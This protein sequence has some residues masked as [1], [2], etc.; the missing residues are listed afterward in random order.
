MAAFL[1]FRHDYGSP[2][3][4][5][6]R[7]WQGRHQKQSDRLTRKVCTDRTA[8]TSDNRVVVGRYVRFGGSA[9]EVRTL[10]DAPIEPVH[11][12]RVQP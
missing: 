8:W 7:R 5:V 4:V 2:G 9:E 12:H 11:L 6:I 3:L 10:E 1:A